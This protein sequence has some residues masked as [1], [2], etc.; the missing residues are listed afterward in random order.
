MDKLSISL[1]GVLKRDISFSLATVDNF[2]DLGYSEDPLNLIN[3]K[4]PLFF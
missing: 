3:K 1:N 2:I 4:C